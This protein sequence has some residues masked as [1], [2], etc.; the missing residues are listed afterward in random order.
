MQLPHDTAWLHDC[1]SPLSSLS[2]WWLYR[3]PV[4]RP[5]QCSAVCPGLV[6]PSVRLRLIVT[7]TLIIIIIFYHLTHFSLTL[8]SHYHHHHT[9]WHRQII[10]IYTGL[11]SLSLPAHRHYTIAESFFSSHITYSVMQRRPCWSPGAVYPVSVCAHTLW[12]IST[13]PTPRHSA[14]IHRDISVFISLR[15]QAHKILRTYLF[16]AAKKLKE[17]NGF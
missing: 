8:W 14:N 10:I 6:P 15:P 2:V 7:N 4:S 1:M 17:I 13:P 5:R 9:H 16:L 11:V 3:I 12:C